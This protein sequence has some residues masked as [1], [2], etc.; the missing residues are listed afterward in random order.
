METSTIGNYWLIVMDFSK[1]LPPTVEIV[2]MVSIDVAIG[3]MPD[4]K[5]SQINKT[6]Q[7]N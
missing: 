1:C 2:K 7:R 6:K 5:L 4:V 3:P